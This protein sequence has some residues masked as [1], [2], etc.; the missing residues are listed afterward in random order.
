MVAGSEAPGEGRDGRWPRPVSLSL[1]DGG[2]EVVGAIGAPLT[3]A[4]GGRGI[5]ESCGFPEAS[6]LGREP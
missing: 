5:A 4:L 1:E 6:R 2:I 3:V